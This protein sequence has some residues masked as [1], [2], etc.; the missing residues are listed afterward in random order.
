MFAISAKTRASYRRNAGPEYYQVIK[1]LQKRMVF[2]SVQ[3]YCTGYSAHDVEIVTEYWK[4]GKPQKPFAV[5][6]NYVETY[7]N[8]VL[9]NTHNKAFIMNKF[10]TASQL[11]QKK[12]KKWA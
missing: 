2:I 4:S 12:K 7:F 10:L 11:K 3:Y 6:R 8:V 5:T 9:T 1:L